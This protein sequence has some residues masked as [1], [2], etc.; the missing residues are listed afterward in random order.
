MA[1]QRLSSR[2][3]NSILQL[4]QES[5]ILSDI[6]TDMQFIKSTIDG[7]KELNSMLNS[8]I[9]SA[10]I[11]TNVLTKIFGENVKELT[12]KFMNLLVSKSREGFLL[13]ICDTF[14]AEYNKINKIADVTLVTAIPATETM[15]KE[16]TDFLTK[17]GKYSKVSISQEVDPKIIGGFI[18]KMDD[19]LLDNSIQRKLQKVRK[20]FA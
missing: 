2:Y 11:K 14:I 16:V 18:L 19:Q 3:A 20:E 5:N 6:F 12:S 7:S 10:E 9:V 1:N 4:A 15:M 13:E 17:S 8:P